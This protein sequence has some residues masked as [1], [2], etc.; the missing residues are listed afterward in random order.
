MNPYVT[1]GLIVLLSVSHGF[2]FFKGR[3]YERASWQ[4]KVSE[5]KD[6]ARKTEQIWQGAYNEASKTYLAKISVVNER[7]R[8][9]LDGL[10]DRPD[11]PLP[12][13]PRPDCK[14]TTGANLS[15]QDAGFLEREAARGDRLREALDLCYR[16]YDSLRK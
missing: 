2:A 7:L 1:L 16:T 9:A 13:A 14:G 5:A 15:R 3:G 10:R 4:A 11:R 8:I 12:G 6:E